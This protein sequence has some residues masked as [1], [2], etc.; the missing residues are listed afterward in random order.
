MGTAVARGTI[1]VEEGNSENDQILFRGSE[2]FLFRL[3]FLPAILTQGVRQ[4]GRAIR[5]LP[6]IE[7][8][9]SREMN[10]AGSQMGGYFRQSSRCRNVDAKRPARIKVHRGGGGNRRAV[11]DGI[12]P[13]VEKGSGQPFVILYW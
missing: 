10:E 12:R 1:T 5:G 13:F 4:V 3:Q 7:N 6:S 9:V 11:D 8:H 2:N